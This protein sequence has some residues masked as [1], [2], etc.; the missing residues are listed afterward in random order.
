MRH[1]SGFNLYVWPHLLTCFFVCFLFYFC[2]YFPEV[3]FQNKYFIWR[4]KKKDMI[5]SCKKGWGCSCSDLSLDHLFKIFDFYQV[6]F[7]SNLKAVEV[8][9]QTQLFI[10]QRLCRM[11]SHLT[12]HCLNSKCEIR[13]CFL[14]T[15]F[16][17][18]LTVFLLLFYMNLEWTLWGWSY[19]LLPKT[20]SVC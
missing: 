2:H 11:S 16:L 5:L 3:Y 8:W 1:T 4:K 13:V 10:R 15:E 19:W 18:Q 17:L 6:K 20:I 12:L 7:V 9:V 14:L